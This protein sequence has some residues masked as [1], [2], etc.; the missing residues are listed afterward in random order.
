MDI[1]AWDTTVKTKLAELMAFESDDPDFLYARDN[2]HSDMC[3]VEHSLAHKREGMALLSAA[4][5]HK[6]LTLD[7]YYTDVFTPKTG[8]DEEVRLLKEFGTLLGTTFGL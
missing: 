8:I 7:A 3:R 5:S 2:I 6:V 1:A 4:D